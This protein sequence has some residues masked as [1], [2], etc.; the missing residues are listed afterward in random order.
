MNII[1]GKI[2]HKIVRSECCHQPAK[3]G[4]DRTKVLY[5]LPYCDAFAANYFFYSF[6][7][8]IVECLL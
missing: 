2:C 5:M 6:L 4:G 3:F 1:L 7:S 8:N